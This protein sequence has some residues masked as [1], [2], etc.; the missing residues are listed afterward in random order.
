M[1]HEQ[2]LH[3]WH[4]QRRA[5]AFNVGAVRRRGH[6]PAGLRVSKAEVGSIGQQTTNPRAKYRSQLQ[7]KSAMRGLSLSVLVRVFAVAALAAVGVFLAVSQTWAAT[8]TLPGTGFDANGFALGNYGVDGNW[9]VSGAPYGSAAY[10]IEPGDP[11][12]GAGAGA[13]T[14]PVMVG[15][16]LLGSTTTTSTV[17]AASHPLPTRIRCLS[18]WPDSD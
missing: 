16:A 9:T 12:W 14:L 3:E 10:V 5:G 2:P 18:V 6:R 13:P 17:A 1:E 15:R 7:R 11:D 8:M 4:D